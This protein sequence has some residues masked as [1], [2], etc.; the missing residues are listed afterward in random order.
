MSQMSNNHEQNVFLLEKCARG[1][2]DA[3]E[4]IIE[5]NLGLVKS[6]AIRFLGRGQDL[7]DLIQIG[8]IGMLKAIRG[9]D[10]SY[11][12]AFSTYAVPLITGEIKRFLRDDGI[13]KISRDIKKNGY[14]LLKAKQ[15]FINKNSRE[16]KISE[17]CQ[18]CNMTT[19]QVVTALEASMPTVSL[20]EK[21]GNDDSSAEIQNFFASN[22]NISDTVE[23]IALREA[24]KKLPEQEQEIIYLRYY[25]GLTQVKVA[26][27]LGL[28]QVKVSRSEK[29]ILEKLRKEFE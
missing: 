13:V 17:L 9:F 26:K 5:E 15:E 19:E 23:K 16:P 7:E 20:Q 21:V 4:K 3:V 29:K 12:T 25:K 1:D 14:I 27:F 28:T 11:N 8:T 24:V 18:I 6:I 2:N 10:F 22:D